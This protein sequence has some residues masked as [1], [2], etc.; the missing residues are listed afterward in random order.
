M[1]IAELMEY[2]INLDNKD[3]II[4]VLAEFKKNVNK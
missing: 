3:E 4:E 1:N 2:L